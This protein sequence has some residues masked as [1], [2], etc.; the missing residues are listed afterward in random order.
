MTEI[1]LIRHTQAQG[2]RYRM[3]QGSWDGAITALGRRQIEALAERFSKIPVD[4]VYSSDLRRA[5]LT[6]EAAARR[7]QL[8]IQTRTALRELDVGPWEKCF[9][10]NIRHAQPELA[11]AFLEDAEHWRLEGA[12]TF[13]EVR[14]RAL[15]E[16]R[17]IAQENEG[18]T[19]AVASHGITIRCIM[20]GITGISLSEPERLPIFRNTAVTRLLWDGSTFHVD[21]MNDVS[22]LPQDAQSSWNT[23]GDLRDERFD[24]E[25]DRE[26]YEACYA[27]AWRAAHGSL[28]G[29]SPD[30]YYMAAVR[31]DRVQ[32]GSVLR[33]YHGEEPVGLV[34]LDPL[35]GAEQG[36]GWISL[37][38][39]KE[40]CR[41]QGYG[42]Q[43]LARAIFFYE[44]RNRT[45]LRLQVA[46][47]NR[48]A[49][50]FYEREGFH[51]I[52]EQKTPT[53]RLLVMERRGMA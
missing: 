39:L 46:E 21:Y 27:D 40:G 11:R 8:P 6:A 53:G 16:L 51:R 45:C 32:P 3:M 50:A 24:P 30:P 25:R 49:C 7:G 34:D 38:Y 15:A 18:K 1:Y 48:P 10:G 19:V 23:A 52:A 26:Y 33:M 43:L 12:E 2:N 22:H 36:V 44:A 47:A 35:R 5:V 42:I 9:F 28:Y 31:H 13:G 41:Y 14:R 20:S 4:A 17:R 37:L 29:F